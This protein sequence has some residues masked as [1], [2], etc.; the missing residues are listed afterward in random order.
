MRDQPLLGQRRVSLGCWVGLLVCTT[1]PH[2]KPFCLLSLEW[3]LVWWAILRD[4]RPVQG[5]LC[6]CNKGGRWLFRCI[7]VWPCFGC[8]LCLVLCK[9]LTFW[10]LRVCCYARSS[11]LLWEVRGRQLRVRHVQLGVGERTLRQELW[12]WL[13]YR[14]LGFPVAGCWWSWVV[15][16][17]C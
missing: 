16:Y 15:E 1:W 14:W 6:K 5:L 9:A 3:L 7:L 12:L 10:L 4:R 2:C 17:T 11:L 13:S 8:H